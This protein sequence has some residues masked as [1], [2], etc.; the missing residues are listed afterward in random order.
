MFDLW[1][2]N[3]NSEDGF[4]VTA[5]NNLGFLPGAAALGPAFAIPVWGQLALGAVALIQPILSLFSR[6]DQRAEE[7]ARDQWKEAIYDGMAKI[8]A[9]VESCQITP[10]DGVAAAKTLVSQYYAQCDT[11]KKKSVATSCRNFQSIPGGF[12]D[13]IGRIQEAGKNCTQ[14][15]SPGNTAASPGAGST[16]AL[17]GL[18]L[19]AAIIAAVIFLRN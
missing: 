13:R 14:S 18:L 1:S 4:I 17:S 15:V 6:K 19:S 10:A 16:G 12:D 8:Q 7:T 9:A 11:F 5:N 3:V 2:Q